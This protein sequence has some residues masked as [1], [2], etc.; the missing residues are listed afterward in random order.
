MRILCLI[1]SLLLSHLYAGQMKTYESGDLTANPVRVIAV[2]KTPEPN[3]VEITISYPE[4]KQILSSG[5]KAN[6]NF[7]LRGF[8]LG[9]DSYSFRRSKDL[10]NSK[11]GQTVHIIVDDNPYIAF[12]GPSMDPF[13]E[14]GDFYQQN[15]RL[16]LPYNLKDGMHTLRVFPC[17]SYGESLKC[18][19]C[20]DGITF[21]VRDQKVVR[22]M[23]LRMPY[24]TYNEPSDNFVYPEG[25]PILLDFYINNCELSKDGYKVRL[26]V[27]GKR[28][29]DLT[30]WTPYYLYDLD[31]GTHAVR[32][33]LLD[34]N[35]HLVPGLFNDVTQ[36]IKVGH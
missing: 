23:N 14:E 35:D 17:R 21:Y 13:D 20:Y 26:I 18:S 25:G 9:S 28:V 32:L 10:I 2:K 12:S 6:L 34:G 11:L 29:R 19:S 1:T 8:S 27:D 5:R 4:N 15:Y 16:N 7:R 33:Q 30:E 3:N 24:L 22:T 36:K 31:R